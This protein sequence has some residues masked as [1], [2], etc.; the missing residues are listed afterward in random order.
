[1][2]RVALSGIVAGFA[3]FIWLSLIHLATPLGQVG[4][5]A[6]P[7]EAQV[8]NSIQ[9]NVSE[10]GFYLFPGAVPPENAT[11]AEKKAVL[12][13]AMEKMK[14][15]PTGI[16]VV[17]P[18]GKAP[19]SPGQLVTELVNDIAQGLLLAW[20]LTQTAITTISGKM[21]FALV[22]GVAA[23]ML[24]NISYWNWYGFPTDYTVS[25]MFGEI[26]GYVVMGLAIA[27]VTLRS[28]VA[29]AVPQAA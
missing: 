24:T 19:L 7:N 12:N 10:Q 28:K 13:A 16:L 3:F 18:Q 6:I 8:V 4:V 14:T 29:S 9:A 2:K 17:F 1:M 26:S 27:V 15:S 20:L 5:R 21:R 22:V 11:A 25:Y 23:S